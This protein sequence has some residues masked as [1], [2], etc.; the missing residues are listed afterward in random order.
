MKVYTVIYLATH[1][2]PTWRH[3]TYHTISF[4]IPYTNLAPVLYHCSLVLSLLLLFWPPLFSL[5]PRINGSHLELGQSCTKGNIVCNYMTKLCT[6]F[7]TYRVL[8]DNQLFLFLNSAQTY[9]FCHIEY[10]R[11]FFIFF[12]VF[13]VVRW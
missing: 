1:F 5:Y 10:R 4:S 11:F 3:I 7:D 12:F 2:S 6:R 8:S 9:H 13:F